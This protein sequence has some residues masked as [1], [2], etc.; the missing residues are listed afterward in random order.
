MIFAGIKNF[1]VIS[2]NLRTIMKLQKIFKKH[3]FLPRLNRYMSSRRVSMDLNNALI[4]FAMPFFKWP[5]F[6]IDI[7][8]LF[9]T[10]SALFALLIINNFPYFL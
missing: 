3:F 8:L 2:N 5:N 4:C 1:H 9:F 6:N 10:L 7:F